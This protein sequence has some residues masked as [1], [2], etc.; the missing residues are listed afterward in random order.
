MACAI[1]KRV[2]ENTI[3][4]LGL[5]FVAHEWFYICNKFQSSTLWQ[6]KYVWAA[7]E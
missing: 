3:E 2:E 1:Y 4:I 7:Y 6:P 5:Y